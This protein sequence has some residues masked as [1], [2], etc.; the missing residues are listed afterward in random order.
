MSEAVLKIIDSMVD[1]H[2]RIVYM[3]E[4]FT[5]E[6]PATRGELMTMAGIPGG[7]DLSWCP[8]VEVGIMFYAPPLDGAP[9]T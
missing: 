9:K 1:S 4:V 8:R 5:W 6:R 7:A 3:D 2:K